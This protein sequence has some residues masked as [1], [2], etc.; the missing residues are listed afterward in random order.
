MSP[1]DVIEY[2]PVV[3]IICSFNDIDGFPRHM[4]GD[5]YPRAVH[6]VC[7]AVP[8]AIPAY[9]DGYDI[10]SLLARL[11]GVVLTGGAANVE[12]HHY[13]GGPNRTPDLRDPR[14]DAVALPLARSAVAAGV[15]LFGICRG[16]Q[17]M[18]VAFGGSLHQ[19]LHEVEGR[20]DHRR[21]R[22]LPIEEQLRPRQRVALTPGA[23][24][25]DL[26][27][28]TEQ[29]VNSLHGQGIDRLGERLEVEAV[30]EDGTIE[31]V[32]VRDAETFALGV[33]WHNEW[34]VDGHP[35]Y[36]ALFREF[37]RAVRSRVKQR[38]NGG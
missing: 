38:V 10:D 30:A 22:H 12:P 33:Q 16:I 19:I 9:G 3:G 8:V 14:R 32:R 20:F 26:S 24:L 37:G 17:E 18:N 27:A 25:A 2:R 34:L 23:L 13:D 35:F 4:L 36:L 11:D 29:V 15:P 6:D 31:A 5:K 28:T 7:E 1:R 21:E